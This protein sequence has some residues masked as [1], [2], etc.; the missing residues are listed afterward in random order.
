MILEGQ[1]VMLR[2]LT[3]DDAAIT[4]KWRTSGRA[5][6]LNKG[7]QSVAEQRDWI[8]SRPWDLSRE[9]NFIQ[10]LR[11][12]SQPVGMISLVDI[13][14]VHH[15]AEPAHF[16]IGEPEVVKGKP[17]A[18]EATKLIYNL[19]FDILGL[20]RVYGPIASENKGMLKFHLALGMKEEGRLREHYF[21]NGTWQDA[22]MVGML[23]E[24]YRTK[25]LPKLEALI[26]SMGRG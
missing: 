5:F 17:V 26:R 9:V 8:A 2:P 3:L 12:T 22:V 23:E 13:D 11:Q 14:L 1:Y 16:L 24:E 4:Q 6:L 21:L 25:A 7:A 15:R 20:H 10:L 18:L 19:A